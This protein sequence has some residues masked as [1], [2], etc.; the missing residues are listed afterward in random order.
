METHSNG[1]LWIS[2]FL[3]SSI[4]RKSKKKIL[5]ICGLLS[6]M[7]KEKYE[8]CKEKVSFEK[9]NRINEVRNKSIAPHTKPII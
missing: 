1:K 8:E 2:N 3:F 6:G 5:W 9:K 4:N 7:K